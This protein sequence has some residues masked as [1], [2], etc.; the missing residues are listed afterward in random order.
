M[1]VAL[2][3]QMDKYTQED[4]VVW[5]MLFERQA[6]NLKQKGSQ[7][8]LNALEEMQEVLNK[9]IIPDFRAI[10]S[11]FSGNTGWEIAVVPGLIPVAEFFTLLAEKKFCS[12]TWLRSMKNLDYL[13]EPDMFHDVFGHIPL[14]SNDVFSAFAHEFGQMGLKHINNEQALIKLQRLYWFTIEFGVIMEEHVKAYG[15]GIMSSF[16]E[17]NRI[18]NRECTFLEFDIEAILNKSF[19]TDEMQEEYFVIESLDQLY[20]SLGEAERFL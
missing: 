2:K 6:E 9:S 15:A 4:F 12:S 18:A 10:N 16:G 3:Q 14:L 11:H 7:C 17:T 19:K 13:E 5:K 20:N 8:Y 1:E